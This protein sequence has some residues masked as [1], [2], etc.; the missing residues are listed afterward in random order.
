MTSKQDTLL[1][2][3]VPSILG[4][5]MN[6]KFALD[7]AVRSRADCTICFML[8]L[9]VKKFCQ[10]LSALNQCVQYQSYPAASAHGDSCKVDNHGVLVAS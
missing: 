6:K 10:C 2:N 7:G 3:D 9:A 1:R 5:S 4:M 8:G